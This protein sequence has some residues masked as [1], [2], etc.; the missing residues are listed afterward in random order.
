MPSIWGGNNNDEQHRRQ[1]QTEIAPG[2]QR[3]PLL[4]QIRQPSNHTTAS[5]RV[6]IGFWR[7]NAP[8]SPEEII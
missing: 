2:R 3:R 5:C 8:I 7:L 4:A 1:R 6:E